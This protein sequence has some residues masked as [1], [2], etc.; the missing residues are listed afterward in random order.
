MCVIE[1]GMGESNQSLVADGA[2]C[3]TG[4]FHL[5]FEFQVQ[6]TDW[7]HSE[8][9]TRRNAQNVEAGAVCLLV[10]F[11]SSSGGRAFCE[12]TVLCSSGCDVTKV[13]FLT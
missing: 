9:K 10:S 11:S 7:N 13:F 6:R 3:P 2:V 12:L 5:V 8:Q 1:C 4:C